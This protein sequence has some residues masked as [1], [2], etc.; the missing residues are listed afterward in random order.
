MNTHETLV[1]HVHLA[2][3]VQGQGLMQSCRQMLADIEDLT[4]GDEAEA[5]AIWQALVA[6]ERAVAQCATAAGRTVNELQRRT[7]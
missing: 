3:F 2:Q 7:A 5:W 6:M 4:T 1:P